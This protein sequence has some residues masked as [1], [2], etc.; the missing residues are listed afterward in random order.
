LAVGVG[1]ASNVVQATA[2]RTLSIEEQP[3]IF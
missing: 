2:S 1:P 3:V